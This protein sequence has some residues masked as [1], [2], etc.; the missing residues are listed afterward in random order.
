MPCGSHNGAA[1]FGASLRDHGRQ[2]STQ[3]WFPPRTSPV[4]QAESWPEKSDAWKGRPPIKREIFPRILGRSESCPISHHYRTS[5][6]SKTS[7]ADC[8]HES[9]D[10]TPPWVMLTP[11]SQIRSRRR[12]RRRNTRRR[13]R[14][15]APV[16]AAAATRR[17]AAPV[18]R[19]SIHCCKSVRFRLGA[20]AERCRAVG[21]EPAPTAAFCAG[22]GLALFDQILRPDP[23]VRRRA[24]PAPGPRAATAC[25]ALARLAR[26]IP[27]CATPNIS[28][29]LAAHTS[30]AGRSHR[31]WRV[32]ALRSSRLDAPTLRTAADLLGLSDA[33]SFEGLA[34]ASAGPHD[35]RRNSARGGRGRE[36][37]GDETVS[38][39]AAR[40]RRDFRAVAE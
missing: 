6:I 31:L 21:A 35:R 22:A 15:Q 4:I 40:R 38:R 9:D 20:A 7:A 29:R 18:P 10:K 3:A 2:S 19:R 14:G 39:R 32:F 28:R 36:R 8:W 23:P 30:P 17:L 25:A 26:T 5:T 13:S 12:P 37:R 11:W 1:N 33:A 16:A 34:D 24:T 27:R